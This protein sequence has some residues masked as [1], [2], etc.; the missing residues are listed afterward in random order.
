M[1]HRTPLFFLVS[2]LCQSL[3]F[4]PATFLLPQFFQGVKGYAA[5]EAGRQMIPYSISIACSAFIGE[6]YAYCF[7]LLIPLPG[8]MSLYC[9]DPVSLGFNNSAD[10]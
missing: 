1:T 4:I 8:R 5:E 2:T 7:T 6:L 10:Y 9:L 3:M